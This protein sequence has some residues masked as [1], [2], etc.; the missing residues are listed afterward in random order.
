MPIRKIKNP[1]NFCTC[2]VCGHFFL[3]HTNTDNKPS[4]C[5]YSFKVCK[6]KGFKPKDNLEF[7]EW[8]YAKRSV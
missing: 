2:R 6:C 7:L 3:S 5:H 1:K 8:E 4:V